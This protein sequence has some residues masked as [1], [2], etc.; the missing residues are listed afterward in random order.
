MSP[1]FT[2]FSGATTPPH[3]IPHPR[4]EVR[5]LGH[6][7]QAAGRAPDWAKGLWFQLRCGWTPEAKP[8]LK[9]TLSYRTGVT[10][11][12][13]PSQ[14]VKRLLR[15]R[16]GGFSGLQAGERVVASS[17]AR[18]EEDTS[19]VTPALDLSSASIQPVETPRAQTVPAPALSR[20]ACDFHR[21]C[22]GAAQTPKSP[23]AP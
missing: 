8:S 14:G 3:P 16:R 20:P 9:L 22:Q 19:L 21:G 7:I 13:P 15:V 10:L 12:A 4:L 1:V 6:G 11:L 23:R 2:Q 17:L 18:G 5:N